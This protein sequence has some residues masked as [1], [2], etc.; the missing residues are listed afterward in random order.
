MYR[1][2]RHKVLILA[3]DMLN[4]AVP[5]KNVRITGTENEL[6]INLLAFAHRL[7]TFVSEYFDDGYV[8]VSTSVFSEIQNVVARL[9][10]KLMTG[11]IALQVS[12][13]ADEL[14]CICLALMQTSQQQILNPYI[15]N[16]NTLID[17]IPQYPSYPVSLPLQ[18]DYCCIANTFYYQLREFM[19]E[20]VI[21]FEEELVFTN[22]APMALGAI[23]A[24]GVATGAIIP[25]AILGLILT[26][27]IALGRAAIINL[28]NELYMHQQEIVCAVYSNLQYSTQAAVDA[29]DDVIDTFDVSFGD[30]V[31]LK[32]I[33]NRFFIVSAM[34]A[35][36]Q[37]TDWYLARVDD[38]I[39]CA[40][41]GD[42][43]CEPGIAHCIDALLCTNPY[44]DQSISRF[45]CCGSH[46]SVS[47]EEVNNIIVSETFSLDITGAY[48]I[49]STISFT[50]IHD[51]WTVGVLDLESFASGVWSRIG[52]VSA[53][54]SSST[55]IV[56]VTHRDS[57]TFHASGAYRW[58]VR[59]Q[60]GQE[61]DT[62][63]MPLTVVSVCFEFTSF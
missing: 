40:D 41:C 14:H 35:F 44:I 30:R 9:E 61:G 6:I 38:F 26:G 59:G 45:L 50:S 21:P 34:G 56:T 55:S 11:D 42:C 32:T 10:Y 7:S 53:S 1:Y 19:L 57:T 8:P 47:G 46:P 29:V 12:R 63:P 37:E 20:T 60:A 13:M 27:L 5:D 25:A 2:S 23:A 15:E 54:G 36:Q 58:V 28:V 18:E 22:L 62:C 51:D 16:D 31:I 33:V 48:W 17:N 4:S 43:G 49:D 3:Q 24:W 39:S 52:R